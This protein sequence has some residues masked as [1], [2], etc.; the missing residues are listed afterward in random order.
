MSDGENR[1]PLTA[2]ALSRREWLLKLGETTAL[3]GLAGT[4]GQEADATGSDPA[5]E[6]NRGLNNL[7]PGLYEPSLDHLTH[8]LRLNE[9]LVRIPAASQT[10]FVQPRTGVFH[11]RFFT[12]DEYRVVRQ[13]VDLM[14]DAT[15]GS[16]ESNSGLKGLGSQQ[17]DE[18]AE[19]MDLTVYSAAG[20]SEA[21]KR[22]SDQDRTLAIHFYGKDTVEEEE[23][24][25]GLQKTWR[26][27]LGWLADTS[28]QRYSKPFLELGAGQRVSILQSISELRPENREENAGTHLFVLL[29]RQIG[30]GYYTSRQ[31]LEELDY[32]GNF[33]YAESPGCPKGGR[34]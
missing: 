22:L 10:D 14:L 9:G 25:V 2:S 1:K 33:F 31:G 3:L 32:K 26:E 12:S 21:A 28:K 5:G 6:D 15:S 18:I 23:E 30:Q 34:P 4:V 24:T 16:M 29:K 8:A 20:V 17:R 13:L 11:P 7:P 19:W 27:G